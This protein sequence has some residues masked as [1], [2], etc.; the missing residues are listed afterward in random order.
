MEKHEQKPECLQTRHCKLPVPLFFC[1]SGT[2]ICLL[3]SISSEKALSAFFVLSSG[4]DYVD[5]S[6]GILGLQ[7]YVLVVH[8]YHRLCYCDFEFTVLVDQGEMR[9]QSWT[10]RDSLMLFEH[11]NFPKFLY[12]TFSIRVGNSYP[13]V[14]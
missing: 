9:E 10:M 1:P 13:Q 14:C 3:P 7:P 12:C 4:S 11:E 2:F 6:K 8:L 5:V